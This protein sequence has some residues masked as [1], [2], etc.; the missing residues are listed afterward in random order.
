MHLIEAEVRSRGNHVNGVA[1]LLDLPAGT[2]M[3]RLH[4]GRAHFDRELRR[5]A[6]E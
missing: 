3:S 6:D 2:V 4:R 5:Y 1:E